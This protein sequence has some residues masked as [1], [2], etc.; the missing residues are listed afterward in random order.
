MLGASD[1]QVLTWRRAAQITLLLCCFSSHGV[2][3]KFAFLP[4]FRVLLCLFTA[5]FTGCVVSSGKE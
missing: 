2:P 3:C 1:L 5:L 4:H